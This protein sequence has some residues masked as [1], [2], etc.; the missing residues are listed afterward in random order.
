MPEQAGPWLH[1]RSQVYRRGRCSPYHPLAGAPGAAAR[2]EDQPRAGARRR[3]GHRQRHDAG[4]GQAGHRTAGISRT[5]SPT[6]LL[7][8]FNSFAKSVILRV[9]EARDLGEIEPLQLLRSQQGL[10]RRTARRA[11]R[12]REA[13]ARILRVQLPWRSDHH[14]PQDRRHLPA[15]RR[16]PPLRGVVGS[17]QGGF[18]PDYWNKLWGWYET[19][20]F[21][22]VA[23]Y[24]ANSICR[25]RSQGTA[26]EN[27]S[28]LGY[29]QRQSARRKTPN[30][31]T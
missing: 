13:S 15:S 29:R 24:L 21:G 26:A 6:H 1:P 9:N 12:R 4:A 28:L 25:L 3:A 2:R 10:H 22:H 5:L 17:H 31:P 8:R 27:R 19:G 11:A 18:P 16:P 23:A 14:Q 20:G 30:W 7:G